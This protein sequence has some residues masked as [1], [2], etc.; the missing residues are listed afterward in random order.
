MLYFY[1]N[2]A[3]GFEAN[4]LDNLRCQELLKY[5]V[6]KLDQIFVARHEI[7]LLDE[8]SLRFDAQRPESNRRIIVNLCEIFNENS[9]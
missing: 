3:I 1:N 7:K 4:S 6:P 2:F 5:A 8:L 9:K